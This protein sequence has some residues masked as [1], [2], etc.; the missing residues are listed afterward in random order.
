MKDQL[1]EE[2]KKIVITEQ[3]CSASFLQRKLRIGYF[4]VASI[5]DCLEE[6]GIVGE[7]DGARP[8]KILKSN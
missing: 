7:C 6:N 1:Y 4:R 2:A 8:R 3:K 5:I